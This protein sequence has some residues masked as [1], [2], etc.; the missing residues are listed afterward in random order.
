M[1]CRTAPGA[2]RSPSETPRSASRP[3]CRS[4]ASY[5]LGSPRARGR[6]WT[7][8][9]RRALR[10]W[11]RPS[12]STAPRQ[13]REQSREQHRVGRNLADPHV[14]VESIEGANLNNDSPSDQLDRVVEILDVGSDFTTNTQ[15]AVVEVNPGAVAMG[16]QFRPVTIAVQR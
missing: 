6:R 13:G 3:T 11:N 9:L 5:G 7:S 8:R 10:L 4:L 2:C 15:K 16:L 14:G 12:R 1:T